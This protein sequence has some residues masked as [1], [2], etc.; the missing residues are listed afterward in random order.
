MEDRFQMASLDAKTI[1]RIRNLEQD[2]SQQTDQQ[3]VLV[4]YT[5]SS[6]TPDRA[7]QAEIPT[8]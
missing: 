4:A 6:T 8:P 2:L 5:G 3:I 1:E 7:N